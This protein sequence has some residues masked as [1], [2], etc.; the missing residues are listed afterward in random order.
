MIHAKMEKALNGQINEEVFSAY[1]YMSMA[2]YLESINLKGAAQWMTV[3][4]REELSHAEKIYRY[5]VERGG[6]VVLDAVKKPKI[7]WDSPLQVFEEALAHEQHITGCFNDLADLA[8]QLGDHA[9]G[10]TLQWF[11]NE[12][13]EE[14]SS[15][16]DVIQQLKLAGDFGGGLFMIDREL[17]RRTFTPPAP[18]GN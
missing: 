5:L 1:L 16:D 9:T 7:E 17:G 2:A 10:N 12:Q 6:R 3:Q 11:V 18:E 15:A 8:L 13:V 14:E 4:V